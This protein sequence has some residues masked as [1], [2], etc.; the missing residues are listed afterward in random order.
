[1]DPIE[2]AQKIGVVID[3]A[4]EKHHQCRADHK[5]KH[6]ECSLVSTEHKSDNTGGS[7]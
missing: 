3:N 7:L 4:V 6:E 2:K 1:M 5:H